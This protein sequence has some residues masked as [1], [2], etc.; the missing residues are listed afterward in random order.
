MCIL[1]SKKFYKICEVNGGSAVVEKSTR[2]F[3][4]AG[5]NLAVAYSGKGDSVEK[6]Y[7]NCLT[8]RCTLHLFPVAE[9][10][11][12]VWNIKLFTAVIYSVS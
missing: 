1:R 7:K 6:F 12:R 10:H 9:F 4:F 8:L 2:V 11:H 5:S 3:K